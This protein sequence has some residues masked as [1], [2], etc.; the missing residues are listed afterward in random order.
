SFQKPNKEFL[1]LVFRWKD[2]FPSSFGVIPQHFLNRRLFRI[3]PYNTLKWHLAPI[4][5]YIVKNITCK[6]STILCIQIQVEFSYIA[7][8]IG[9]CYPLPITRN[10]VLEIITIIQ[11]FSRF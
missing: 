8:F 11:L 7:I 9:N 6:D 2:K 5:Q 3:P 4:R 10:S 1:L